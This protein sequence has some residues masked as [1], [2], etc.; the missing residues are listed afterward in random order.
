MQIQYNFKALL[1]RS[2]INLHQNIF[3]V[4]LQKVFLITEFRV[5]DQSNPLFHFKL[6]NI[7]C[8]N[9]VKLQCSRD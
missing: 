9:Q 4:N 7:C 8:A 2:I 1:K 5:F 6:H 3:E